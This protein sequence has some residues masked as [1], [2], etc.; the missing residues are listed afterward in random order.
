VIILDPNSDYVRLSEMRGT[1]EPS[2][3]A[4]YAAAAS[5]VSV[6][7]D[8][9]D[10]E[11]P[12]RIQFA[13]VDPAAQAAVLGLDP[14]RDREEY[15]ALSGILVAGEKGRPLISG[16]NALVSSDNPD[17]RQLGLRAANLGLL[18]WSIW[19]GGQGR[20]LVD[21]LEEPTSRCLVVDLGSLGS[22]NEQRL[23]SETVLSTLWR[24]RARREPLLI[25]IDEAHNVCPSQPADA[26]TTLAANYAALIAA[27]GRKFGLYLL[28]STQRPQKVNEEVLSQCDNLLL[29]RMNS[30]A[31]LEYL[32][33]TFSFVP[34]GLIQRATAFKLGETL[35][36]GKFFP[37]ATYVKF[38]A[39][40]SQEGGADIPTAWAS[41]D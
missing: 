23:I 14:I 13:D 19:S 3:A 36:G 27:E 11:H 34:S 24:N 38:G 39:R 2:V 4:E 6:W 40:I 25:V 29:M 17:V 21:E 32:R 35:V 12:L 16:L 31:D 22:I 26:V 30:E 9:P 10:A 1:V 28:T 5:G 7:Q 33:D 8:D 18:K 15:A 41:P 37:H 20:S